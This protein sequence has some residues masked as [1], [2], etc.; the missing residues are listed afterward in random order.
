MEESFLVLRSLMMELYLPN[1]IMNM[2]LVLIFSY[3]KE[4]SYLKLGKIYPFLR[5][6]LQKLGKS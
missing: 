4:V 2:L 5:N 1:I 3:A 6:G